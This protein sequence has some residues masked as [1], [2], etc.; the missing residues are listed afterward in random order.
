MKKTERT[1]AIV[2]VGKIARD[3]HIPAISTTD[4]IELAGIVDPFGAMFSVINP[5][6]VPQQ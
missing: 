6:G 1:V 4:G 3:R 5:T 2:G